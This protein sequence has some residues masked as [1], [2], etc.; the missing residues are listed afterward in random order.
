MTP[1]SNIAILGAG[2]LGIAIADGLRKSGFIKERQLFL[3][4]RKPSLIEHMKKEN[5]HVSDD[6]K[7]A[8]TS[9]DIVI[10]AV[11]PGQLQQLIEEIRPV[12]DPKRHIVVSVITAISIAEIA[13]S[14]HG[15]FMI[16]RAMPNTAVA[17]GESMTCIAHNGV[18]EEAMREVESIFTCVG[19]TLQIEEELMQAATVVC[20]SGIAFWM[21]FIRATTQGGV[22]LGFD[23]KDAQ[24]IAVQTC[25]GA[26]S[27]LKLDNSHPE[28]E[29]DKVTTPQG[30]TIAGLNEMEHHGLSSALIKG[31]VTSFNRINQMKHRNETL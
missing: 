16:V 22:Q 18:Q 3:T 30:C 1:S 28:Q 4:R 24:K 27:L 13:K 15:G 26:A 7:K 25:M 20:A 29:I 11:Q 10:L 2:N 12:L 8:V 23:A 21:R 14:L 31:L 5:I 17:A 9:S 6:N 19:Q